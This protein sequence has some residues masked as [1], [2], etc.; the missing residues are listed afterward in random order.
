MKTLRPFF[1][2]IDIGFIAYWLATAL[3][4]IPPEWAFSNYANPIVVAWN[5]SFL[6][7]DLLISATGLTS[8]WLF[9]RGCTG[10]REWA[11]LSLALTVASGLNA[12]AFWAIRGEFDW[13]WWLP[14]LYLMLYPLAFIP[15]LLRSQ[16]VSHV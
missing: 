9:T 4:L 6:P 8:V 2:V 15:K 7:L 12:I 13:L 3:K 16:T 1:L 5:W 10:W 11:L 14:N